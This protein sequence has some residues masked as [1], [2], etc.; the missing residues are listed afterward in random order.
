MSE[1]S[2]WTVIPNEATSHLGGLTFLS[3]CNCNSKDLNIKELPL[4]YER[5]LQYWFEFKDLQS[6]KM[7]CTNKT[8]I[9][10]NQDIKIDNKTI[11]F[12]TWFD[13]G[14]HTVKD[15]VDQNLDF[16][17]YE[18]FQLRYQ[19]Q[20]NFLTY[21][22]LI[23][24]IPQE[25]KKALKQTGVLSEHLI[26]PW[27]NLK[28]LTTKVIH[29]SFVKH[30]FEEPTVKQRLTANGLPPDQISKYFNIAFS[31]TLETK[32]TMFQYKTLR[33]IVFTESKLFKAKLASSDLCYLCLKTKQDLKHMLVSCPVVTKFWKIFLEWHETLTAAKLE[34]TTVKI[35]YGIIENDRFLKLT[36][37]LLLIAKYYIY[38]CSI[39][40]EPLY[41]C[42]YLTIVISKAEI[43]K[44]ISIRTNSNERY[45]N[46]WKPLIDKELVT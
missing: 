18:E 41:F 13:K 35:L 12:R 7:S 1:N 22:G 9:W 28:V 15:L 45:Y 24:A 2:A 6:N 3:T 21:Y 20:T 34:L 26:Q 17:T 31:I 27:E 39:N 10:N 46:K 40:K 4:F 23:N 38:C 42:T 5:M 36:N 11:F 32:L 43:E 33:D 16:L 44:Q 37:H 14:V 30:M 29:K 8:T 19:L 25:Y